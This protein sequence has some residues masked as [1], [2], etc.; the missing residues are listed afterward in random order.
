MALT[1]LQK[2]ILSEIISYVR[3]ENLPVGARLTE[4]QFANL[5]GTAR[6]PIRAALAH[7]K[8]RKIVRFERSRGFF[9]LVPASSLADL[10]DEASGSA[11][12]P[13][14]QSIA[15]GRLNHTIPD[16]V[17]ESELIRMFGVTR[18]R[19]RKVLARILEEG[20]I[21]RRVGHGWSFLPML[22]S[23]EAY[24]ESLVFRVGVETAGILSPKFHPSPSA[25]EQ[26]RRRQEFIYKEGLK[27]LTPLEVWTENAIFHETIAAWSGNRFILQAVKRLARLQGLVGSKG[28]GTPASI[29][30]YQRKSFEEH[31]AILAKIAARDFGS[32]ASLMRHHLEAAKDRTPFLDSRGRISV[33]ISS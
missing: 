15:E 20:W 7:L 9:L 8:K 17:M 16:E 30:T 6:S 4:L 26:C 3:R 1:P 29:P 32:A 31:V 19:L 22:D 25:L 18:N 14:Y 21:E 11:G 27:T 12:D 24:R 23:N 33:S 5:L 10:A 28:Q 13:L 2:R